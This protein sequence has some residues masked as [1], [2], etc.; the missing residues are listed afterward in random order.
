MAAG[1]DVRRRQAH[2]AQPRAVGAAADRLA[3]R[4]QA[5]GAD[6]GDRVLDDLRERLEVRAVYVGRD[7]LFDL[8]K[9]LA[10]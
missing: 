8:V 9:V 1:E 6:R 4:L 2:R 5:L 10:E 7:Y 3:Q